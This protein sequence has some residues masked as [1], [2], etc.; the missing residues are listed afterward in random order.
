MT[1]KITFY[2]RLMA[3][4]FAC[5]A[6][7]TACVQEDVMTPLAGEAKV[8]LSLDAQTAF[9]TNTKAYVD[10]NGYKQ[11]DN[12]TVEIRKNNASGETVKSAKYS[13]LKSTPISLSR[14]DYYVKA[15]MGREEAAS[16]EV[17]Y[18]TDA[19]SF[20]ILDE[21]TKTISLNCK[22]TCAKCKVVFNDN[23]AEY[24]SDYYITYS[25]TALG[26][27]VATWA[28]GDSAPWY[29]KVGQNETVKA[30]IHYARK[31][32]GKQQT[33]EWS[34]SLSPNEGWTLKVSAN[35]NMTEGSMNVTITIDDSTNDIPIDITVPSDWINK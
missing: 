34:R 4:A 24:F 29:L 1:N 25:T 8:R 35:N 3:L 19:T 15:Y 27:N 26:N 16:R 23:M 14:G 6:L 21:S 22:P 11:I 28:K 18:A 17:F 5:G 32:D 12:Y 20:S 2:K 7:L 13:E 9:S 33:A 30:T 10:E 31:S